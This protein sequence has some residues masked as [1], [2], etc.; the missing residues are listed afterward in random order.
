MQA[1]HAAAIVLSE[2]FK[3]NGSLSTI[4]DVH[5][6]QV[7]K[8]ADKAFTK[9]LCFGVCR[10][11]PRLDWFAKGLLKKPLRTK[12]ADVY[13]LILIGLYQIIY[14][15]TPHHAAVS[16]TAEISRKLGKTWAVALVNG[17]LRNFVRNE[18]DLISE[19][20]KHPV[21][22]YGFSEYLL[23]KIERAWPQ[24]WQQIIAASNAPPPFVVRVNENKTSVQQYQTVLHAN[25]LEFQKNKFV[26]TALTLAQASDVEKLPGFAE[27][28]VSVQDASAQL[29]PQLLQARAH[30]RVL[31]ACAAPGGKTGHLLEQQPDLQLLALDV[32]EVRLRRVEDNLQRLGLQAETKVADFCEPQTWSDGALYDYILLDAP[33][34]GTGVLRRNPDIKVLLRPEQIAKLQKTQFTM[35]DTAW[36]H[37]APGGVILYVTCSILPEEN[38]E[39]VSSW[40]TTQPRAKCS[41]I[42][43]NWGHACDV[44][45]QILPGEENMDG[46]YFAKVQKPA[47]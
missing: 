23:Q 41:P 29:V 43:A 3:E 33:C 7:N 10:Y 11:F 45:Q 4:L 36:S 15:K 9:E 22:K 17:L 39:L 38:A 30:S 1:R 46:F 26:D 31:D 37:L 19:A 24:H 44:G 14:L 12:D 18:Q 42:E 16:A 32:S 25:R 2:I 8:D 13:A 20:N 21:A 28:K 47:A 34:S 40:L 5:C 6:A 27:G 35:L